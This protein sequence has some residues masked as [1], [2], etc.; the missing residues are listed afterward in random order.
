MNI[1]INYGNDVFVLPR[2]AADN[3]IQADTTDLKTLLLLA[4]DSALRNN[5][6]SGEIAKRIGCRR[7][8]AEASLRF[9]SESGVITQTGAEKKAEPGSSEKEESVNGDKPQKKLPADEVPVYTGEELQSLLDQN[10]GSRRRM[11]DECQNIAG[12]MFNVLEINKVIAL[13]EYLGLENEHILM[14]FAYCR[15]RGKTSVHYIERTAYNL[16]NEGIDSL[17][18]LETYIKAKEAC[19]SAEGKLRKLFGFG[20]RTL[21]PSERSYIKRWTAEFCYTL[22]IIERA[23]QITIDNTHDG[24]VSLA[25]MNR[26]LD[27][28]HTAGYTAIAEID[29]ALEAYK[30]GKER[31]GTNGGGSFDTDEFFA[32]ALKRSY[33]NIK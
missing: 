11:L 27:N 16:Y 23:Y 12:K 25:Y 6:D 20:E 30:T 19:E 17:A 14:L 18:K 8:K 15:T 21:T 4:S 2:I 33:E 32:L 26:I 3:L 29:A 22:E 28:W 31:T 13:S 24:K 7:D 5:C 10:T 9:W 1:Q